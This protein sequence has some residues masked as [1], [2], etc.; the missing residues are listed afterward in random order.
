MPTVAARPPGGTRLFAFGFCASGRNESSRRFRLN[1]TTS[2]EPTMAEVIRH[3]RLQAGETAATLRMRGEHARQALDSAR[4]TLRQAR[5]L[6]A[7][8]VSAWSLPL[9][10]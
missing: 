7:M 4:P 2:R 5:E 8:L 10:D 3:P 1:L 9:P 6:T